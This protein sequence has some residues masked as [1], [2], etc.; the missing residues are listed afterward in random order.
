MPDGPIR[1]GRVASVRLAPNEDLVGGLQRAADDL[2]FSHAIV[3]SGLGSLIDAAFAAPSGAPPRLVRGPAVELVSLVG[4]ISADGADLGGVVG[5]P[6]GSVHAGHFLAGHNPVLVTVE[7]IMEEILPN[8]SP[9]AS[10][11]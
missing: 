1:I 8:P 6:A 7:A 5:D 9:P 4:E 2:G 10:C 11:A 3:R